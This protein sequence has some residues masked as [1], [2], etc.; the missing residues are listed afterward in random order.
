MIEA[1]QRLLVDEAPPLA[2]VTS[3]TCRGRDRR[4]RLGR[5]RP[6]ALRDRGVGRR[7]VP[8]RP[9][10]AS[11][12]PRATTAW[13]RCSIPRTVAT[14]IRSRTAPT[15]VR[16]T[17]S[18]SASRTT[19]PRRRWRAS[20]MC[21]ACLAEYHDPADRRFHAQPNAC[22]ECGPKL[23]WIDL[24]SGS[25]CRRRRR[26]RGC[27]RRVARREDR[28]RERH[29]WL[30]PRRRRHR[31]ECR[32]RAAP[33]QVARRQAVRGDGR[34]PR[35]PP[36]P[37]SRSTTATVRA[38][39][40]TPPADRARSPACRRSVADAV[41]P[42][43]PELGVMLP[44]TP[45][46]HLLLGG[47]GAAARDD[48]R[49]P[50]RRA[51]RARGRRRGGSSCVARRRAAGARPSD[52][53]P[54]RRLGRP[55][56]APGVSRC[57]VARVGTHPNRWRFRSTPRR[58][59]LARR[60]RAQVDDRGHEGARPS[61]RATI[62]ATWSTSPRTRRSCRRSSI[63]RRSTAYVRRSSRTTCIRSTCPRSTRHD[64]DLPTIAVQHHHAHV[65]ACMVEHGR[66][67]PVVGP[68][69]RRAWLRARRDDVGRRGAGRGPRRVSTAWLTFAPRRC[70]AAWPRSASRGGWPRCGRSRA[71]LDVEAVS[72]RHR[73]GDPRRD[74][75]GSL[76]ARRDHRRRARAGSSTR[77]RSFWA[78]AGASPTRRKQPS[79]WRPWPAPCR[80]R[81][82]G[83][84][85][86]AR[87]RRSCRARPRAAAR[88]A[89]G[90]IVAPGSTEPRS[91]PGST[92]RSD[93]RR[94]DLRS[95][96]ASDAG[97]RHGRADGRR[98]PELAPHRGR[99][100]RP[101]RRPG[102]GS[103]PRR[104]HRTTEGSASARPPSP[105]GSDGPLNAAR[106]PPKW[107]RLRTR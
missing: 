62:S 38:A 33:P 93:E 72:A 95:E 97:H 65:A 44:Y 73:P 101:P 83:V 17:R 57:C 75:S 46:H 87:R 77:S 55:G 40:L 66:I 22:G 60:C 56:R 21:P 80:A 53:H 10:S 34:G 88:R 70:P 13:R 86:R 81:D 67:D 89:R 29:R 106:L 59:I 100:V 58:A 16:A 37:S 79:S 27:S 1:L 31:R 28:R 26:P 96:S 71:G 36:R 82:T 94:P 5:A 85:G 54:L 24:Q 98:V 39:D 11:T 41:A 12:R 18:C 92:S 99:R 35:E 84:R 69:V 90:A 23:G 76:P 3:V 19:G 45:L 52:P 105:A 42:G 102:S 74:P 104:L 103:C 30:P 2:R 68:C 4:C 43:L 78:A 20:T 63:C 64:L 32:A 6:A 107:A 25:E 47:D 8:R 15:A 51:D 49:Q 7:P 48:E 91:P 14:A 61:S 50:Q 9:R